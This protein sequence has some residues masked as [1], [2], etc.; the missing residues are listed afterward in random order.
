MGIKITTLSEN[1]ANRGGFIG[2]WGLSILIDTGN[3]KILMDTGM[4]F[5]AVYNAQLLNIDLSGIDKIVLSHG[6]YDHTGGLR[7]VLDRAGGKDIIGHPDVLSP[8]YGKL[9]DEPEHYIGIPFTRQILEGLGANFI[10]SKEPFYITENIMT[11]GEVP[12]TTAYEDVDPGLFIKQD[13]EV[14]PDPL[15]DDLA[16]IIDSDFGLVIIL[17]C[18]HRGIINTVRHAQRLT[19]K[20]PVYAVIGG[21][22]LFKASDQRIEQTAADLKGLGIRMLG[23]S[24]CTGFRAAKRLAKE[25]P[26]SFFMNNAGT[27]FKLP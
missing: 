11:T 24:H 22:H 20:E 9:P 13:G 10:L 5:S 14:R 6:H 19:G 12:L 23:T 18:A 16:L 25:F 7:N 3:L 4:S 17:G 8:K 1:T 2:E 26:D 27:S 15:A 21:T